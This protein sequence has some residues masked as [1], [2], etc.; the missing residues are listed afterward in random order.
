VASW[1]ILKCAATP[2]GVRGVHQAVVRVVVGEIPVEKLTKEKR[3]ETCT[4]NIM[5]GWLG[6]MQ[7]VMISM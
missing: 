4:T 7:A 1:V 3:E 6:T 2:S 5:T